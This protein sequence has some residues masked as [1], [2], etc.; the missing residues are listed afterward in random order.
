MAAP[1]ANPPDP[2]QSFD[3]ATPAGFI[4]LDSKQLT[5]LNGERAYAYVAIDRATRFAVLDILPDRKGT[6]GAAFLTHALAAFPVQVHTGLTDNGGELTD[7]FAVDKPG[8]PEG[9]PSGTHPFDRVC[10]ARGLPTSARGRSVLRPTAWSSAST[11]ASATPSPRSPLRLQP[12]QE[13]LP[14]PGRAHRLPQD[15]R[16]QLQSNPIA[17]P[18]LQSPHRGRTQSPGTQHEG[19][20]PRPRTA[21]ACEPLDSSFRWNDGARGN[22]PRSARLGIKC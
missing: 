18:W 8:K 3:T 10:T 20:Y 19:R 2:A 5:A 21:I 17:M 14:L 13:P 11:D 16:Q 15:L 1:P 22:R 6:T 9:Q 4:H 7:R 12:G